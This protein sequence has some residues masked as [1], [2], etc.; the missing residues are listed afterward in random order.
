MKEK[1]ELSRPTSIPAERRFL[2]PIAWTW[3]DQGHIPSQELV[4]PVVSSM[5]KVLCS[6]HSIYFQNVCDNKEQCFILYTMN[7]QSS[8][9][10]FSTL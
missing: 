5:C 10:D 7:I 4:Q 2:K 8:K 3:G 1:K 6:L 9:Q